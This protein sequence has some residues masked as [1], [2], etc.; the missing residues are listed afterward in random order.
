MNARDFYLSRRFFDDQNFPYGF[1]RSG[2]F[3]VAE[4]KHLEQYG[5]LFKALTEGNV[6]NPSDEDSHFLQ[7]ISGEIQAETVAEKAWLKYLKRCN[8]TPVWLT[9]RRIGSFDQE[10]D[11]S[12]N[13]D[14]FEVEL[15]DDIDD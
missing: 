1:S 15:D 10:D 6:L 7:V 11:D 5:M 2:D 12:I 14:D 9:T 13:D 3:T 4:V 8:R